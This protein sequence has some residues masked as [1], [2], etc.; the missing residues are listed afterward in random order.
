MVRAIWRRPGARF[1]V[2]GLF[3]VLLAAVAV[4]TNAPGDVVADARYE[5]LAAPSQ[6]LERHSSVWDAERSL[7]EPTKYFS[8]A[9]GATQA[10]WHGLGAPAWVVQ[11]ATHVLLLTLA[12]LG[13]MRLTRSVTNREPA[14]LIAGFV[15]MFNPY[16]SQ[17]LLPSGLF[18]AYAVSPWIAWAAFEGM[19]PRTDRWRFAAVIALCVA[20][21][22]AL[23]TASLVLALLPALVLTVFQMLS[24]S[25]P[26]RRLRALA[27]RAGL[28]V[29]GVAAPAVTVLALSRDSL[30]VNL[31]TTETPETVA[32]QSSA[33]ESWRGLGQ[34]LSYFRLGEVRIRDQA[35]PY[36]T[37][38]LVI[39][40]TF[41]TVALAGYVL[42]K[43]RDR[44]VAALAVCAAMGVVIMVG[45]FPVGDPSPFGRALSTAFDESVFARG[46]RS[47]YKAGASLQLALAVLAAL[48]V[49]TLLR[50]RRARRVWVDRTLRFGGGL[51]ICAGLVVA[52]FPY[53]TGRLYPTADRFDDLPEYWEQA[54]AWF[55]S[56]PDDQAVFV[57][58][59]VA[60]TPY[61]WG[62]VNDTLFDA[63]IAQP[64]VSA[65][66]LPQSTAALADLT[67]ALDE[68]AATSAADADALAAA[69]HRMNVRWVLVQNDVD[70][71]AAK[72]PRPARYEFIRTSAS[73]GAVAEFGRPGSTTDQ[74]G[75]FV[76]VEAD[77]PPVEIYELVEPRPAPAV[78]EPSSVVVAGGGEAWPALGRIGW[79]DHAVVYEADLAVADR[80]AAFEAAEAFVVTDGGQ[81]RAQ[82]VWSAQSIRSPVLTPD[83]DIGR[84]TMPLF[85]DLASQTVAHR[86]AVA[87]VTATHFGPSLVPWVPAWRPANALDDNDA[88]AWASALQAPQTLQIVLE[89]PHLLNG[90]RLEGFADLGAASIDRMQVVVSAQGAADRRFDVEMNALSAQLRLDPPVEQATAVAITPRRAPGALGF[91]GLT[92]V[93]LLTAGGRLNGA[94]VLRTPGPLGA[95]AQRALLADLGDTPVHHVFTRGQSPR[96]SAEEP[97]IH[98]FFWAPASEVRLRAHLRVDGDTPLGI[99]ANLTSTS[100]GRCVA[101][102]EIDGNRIEVRA[103][104]P[105]NVSLAGLSE[106]MEFESC[107]SVALQQ[108]W[109]RLDGLATSAGAV[110]IVTVGPPGPG[111][112]RATDGAARAADSH[113]RTPTDRSVAARVVAG[114]LVV[115]GVAAHPGWELR[116]EGV[117]G[118]P[119]IADGFVAWQAAGDGTVTL[120]LTFGPQRWYRRAWVLASVALAVSL[121]I[122]APKRRVRP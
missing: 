35:T 15:Y 55:D 117:P 78:I 76:D 29:A 98:R 64:V 18:T 119:T 36:F 13:A 109:H 42:V 105:E 79:L 43:S 65:R 10:L 20:F 99:L 8:P 40:C 11:R 57:L 9:V 45:I 23:N 88:T 120:D 30:R 5:H 86:S 92:S 69:L 85:D 59:S 4:F 97:T 104:D 3:L 53:W 101:L 114:D 38:P 27:W 22:G 48:A 19:R 93:D 74:A 95:G 46:F 61:V 103:A 115:T 70:W 102:F 50:R 33:S 112:G 6:F 47:T 122:L 121:W 58:P 34:W 87:A 89:E 94:E 106:G 52:S 71:R 83:E 14:W 91:I 96:G 41:L 68:Y 82:R 17:F 25:S 2:A 108:G 39:V 116:A 49:V 100:D 63:N 72:V 37:N 54:F 28:L 1:T 32:M 111:P 7:G 84:R 16:T 73:F 60:R 31:E 75:V 80:A 44:V 12:G 77:L 110:D 62:Y 21:V 56:R 26:F 118:T 66:T 113:V 67:E 90:I 81:L 51:L 24:T 107:A